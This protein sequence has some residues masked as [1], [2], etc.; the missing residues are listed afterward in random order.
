M[1]TG[2]E[3]DAGAE[4][5]GAADVTVDVNI[6]VKE[7]TSNEFSETEPEAPEKS[8]ESPSE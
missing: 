5:E 2:S 7:E 4:P 3:E 1:E 8:E 6:T